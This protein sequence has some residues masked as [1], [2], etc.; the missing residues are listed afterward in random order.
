MTTNTSLQQNQVDVQYRKEVLEHRPAAH[1]VH[2][3]ILN[4]WSSRAFANEAVTEEQLYTVLEAARWA[5]SASNSQPWRF[6]VAKTEDEKSL[7]QQFINPR[8]RVW[9]DKAAAYI[10]IAS[11][12]INKEGNP[13]GSHAF[14]TGA[15]W[16]AIAFQANALGLNT[17]AIGG[18][19]RE[20]ARKVLNVPEDIELHAVIT[21][22]AKGTIEDLDASF[23]EAEKPSARRTLE[24]SIL[25]IVFSDH[26]EST[27]NV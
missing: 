15:A 11:A 14:D 26:T 16:G 9:A 1:P 8:N 3:I 2:P 21:L 25:P 4:R 27:E 12:K 10:L 7:F 18:Y 20:A 19:D 17:R 22:G 13:Q 6:Y 24:E 23:H 5:P